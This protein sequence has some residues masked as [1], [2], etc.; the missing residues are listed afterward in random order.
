[1]EKVE[2]PAKPSDPEKLEAEI[3]VVRTK[4][5]WVPCQLLCYKMNMEAAVGYEN[6]LSILKNL[7][8]ILKVYIIVYFLNV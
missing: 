2:V 7:S 5:T 3:K 4:S 8:A 6:H 1:M